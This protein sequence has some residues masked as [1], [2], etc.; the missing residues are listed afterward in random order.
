MKERY[1]EVAKQIFAILAVAGVVVV[2]ATAPGA[3]LAAK[4]FEGT[5]DFKNYAFRPNPETKTI[6]TIQTSEIIE[7]TIYTASFFPEISYVFRVKGKGFKRH[8]IRL[9]MG[10][11]FDLGESK[12]NLDFIAETLEPNKAFKLERIAPASGLILNNVQL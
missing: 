1:S 3:V 12:V 11:L 8:Q 2:I 6:G 10:V 4:L 7:N 5:H 9:M